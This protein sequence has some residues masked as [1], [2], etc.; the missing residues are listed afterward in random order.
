M[1]HSGDM[2]TNLPTNP[3]HEKTGLDKLSFK[4]YGRDGPLDAIF[5]SNLSCLT[6]SGF[7]PHGMARGPGTRTYEPATCRILVVVS[8]ASKLGFDTIFSPKPGP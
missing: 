3:Q 4:V 6:P 2:Q 8:N 5:R 1:L 7:L